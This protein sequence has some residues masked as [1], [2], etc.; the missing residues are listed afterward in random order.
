MKEQVLRI[1]K[2]VQEGR[3]S[4]EDAFDLMDAFIDFD[5]SS[6]EEPAQDGGEEAKGRQSD[7]KPGSNGKAESFRALLDMMEAIRRE[8]SESIHWHDVAQ[9]VRE[10]AEKGVEALKGTVERIG[11]GGLHWFGP[12]ETKTVE[13]PL[14]IK[15]GKTLKVERFHGDVK[16]IGGR[17][18]P[19]VTATV[20]V[21]GA[22]QKDAR[23]KAAAW[24]PIIEEADDFVLLKQS[25]ESLSEDLELLVPEGVSVEIKAESGDVT[26]KG[27]QSDVRV[28]ALA[29][30]IVVEG[31]RG[32]VEVMSHAGEVTL[33]RIEG[34]EVEIENR[35][36]SVFLHE[37]SG[38]VKVRSAAGDIKATDLKPK[39]ANLE[40]VSGNVMVDIVEPVSTD[41]VIRSVAGDVLLDIDSRSDCRVALS[42]V[43]GAV[44]T[45]IA[46]EEIA[47]SRERITGRMGEGTGSVEVSTVSGAVNLHL[48]D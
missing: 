5:S 48:R 22:S 42:S 39:T 8:I 10:A 30:D 3:L 43:S 21:R 26:V 11:K 45:S 28:K 25:P 34:S 24:T 29:G 36:G 37:V 27:T 31:A 19:K 12:I 6:R 2:M 9:Q 44:N 47:H 38:N 20:S 41:V 32:R 23:T 35:A 17:Q 7:A 14:N 33:S 16:V 40:T 46:L 15:P 18:E 1:L 4:P 13:M